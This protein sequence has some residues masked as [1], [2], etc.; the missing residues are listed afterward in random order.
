MFSQSYSKEK[1]TFKVGSSACDISPQGLR[2][3]RFSNNTKC[4][5][6][7]QSSAI[8]KLHMQGTDLDHFFDNLEI[9]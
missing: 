4:Q 5:Q 3:A 1:V 7:L 8:D 6:K 9:L 2:F